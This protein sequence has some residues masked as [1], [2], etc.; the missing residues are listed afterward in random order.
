LSTLGALA[1]LALAHDARA[2]GN[3]WHLPTNPE[4]G[5]AS[6]RGPVL[7]P[8][9]SAALSIYSGNQFQG[10]GNPNNQ[11]EV[12]SMVHYRARGASS[13]SEAPLLFHSQSGNNKYFLATIAA[14]TFAAGTV[15][16]Y[17]LR[18]AYSD[19][20]TTFVHGSDHQTAATA[21]E[22][23]AQANPFRVQIAW[24]LAPS[25]S[26]TALSFG[27]F[28]A[29]VF[30]TSGH[31]ALFGPDRQGSPGTLHV[32]LAPAR[33][34]VADEWLYL[35][36]IT[37]T[38][39]ITGGLDVTHEVAGDSVV[40]R[41]TSP[42]DGVLRYEIVDWG[43]LTATKSAVM[44]SAAA[45]EH[46]YGFGEKFNSVDQAGNTVRMLTADPPGDKGDLSYKVA[47]WFVSTA[48]Y[49]FHLDASAESRFA[50]RSSAGD[51]FLVELDHPALAYHLVGGPSMSAALGRYT[52]V[53]GRAPL[54]PP[55]AF[56]PWMSS[57]HWR[58]GGEVRYVVT[59]M[60]EHD[61][62]G[63]VF[64]FDSPWETAYNDFTWNEAQFAQGGEY[65][66]RQWAGFGS[67]AEMLAFLKAQGFK[68]VLWMTPF[69]NVSSNDEGVVGQN[70]GQ[71]A[72]YAEA[73]ANGYFVRSSPGGPPLVVTWWKG[74]GSPIDF[75][76]AG[77][78][79]WLED[80]LEA[81]V[82]DGGGAIGGFKTDDGEG[83]FIPL[84]AAYSDGRTGVEMKNAYSLGYH[85]TV[86]N[87]LGDDGVLFARSGFSGSQSFPACWAGD[88]EPN[89]G[90]ENGLR[91]VIVA[92]GSA[93]MSGFAIWGH[94]IG[95]Y[96]ET[97]PSSTPE[98]LFMRWTQF[99]ALSPIMQMHRQVASN[100]H[101]PWS[102]GREAL[103]NY[104]RYAE[105][106]TRLFP[107]LY[108]YAAVARDSGLPILRPLVLRYDT[109]PETYG[110]K[111][112]YL[113][114][115]EL[116]VAPVVDNEAVEREVYLP[117]GAWY[118]YF[119]DTRYQGGRTITWQN[120]D[121]SRMP[122]FVREGAL[123]PHLST[124]PDSLVDAGY[125]DARIAVWDGDLTWRIYP[126]S[127]SSEFVMH[128][129]TRAAS[130]L[131]GDTLVVTLESEARGMLLDVLWDE[132]PAV[133]RDDEPLERVGGA[134][135]LDAATEG[136]TF[137]S[138]HV[139]V[140]LD[141]GGGTTVVRFGAPGSGG[142]G[143]AGGG[144][145]SGVGGEAPAAPGAEDGCGCRVPGGMQRTSP[146][147]LLLPW[148]FAWS[149]RRR[150]TRSSG[151]A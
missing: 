82:A 18:I 111:H 121:Q 108:S 43:G 23:T 147:V 148:L 104:R 112:Q 31:V 128:D 124:I 117:V 29:R 94:D 115:D 63:S 16:E 9:P 5:I 102:Y 140:K 110:L 33:I 35:G 98:N 60:R 15:V 130:A 36:A 6:M 54:P 66:G 143:G 42:E 58:T 14:D 7:D 87:V 134:E 51:R 122:L 28:E 38:T 151:D 22:A 73:A 132:P 86:W 40:A 68:V 107:Y 127:A 129:G 13:W 136:W 41:I 19:E 24:P 88:N 59:R 79:G 142:A 65:E 21:V 83:D 126:A 99:G 150:R 133:T 69:V 47:P 125:A 113:L 2:V 62:P 56:G 12:G 109:D 118:D 120:A 4:P 48:G 123:V 138:G 146:L 46:F 32:A 81:L 67:A 141:H 90:D 95:G 100:N 55:W 96:Q 97:N 57:D 149:W 27:E 17:Y 52:A 114:G 75:T 78:R 105:L 20:E 3:T 91:S 103:D 39:P 61:I 93:A 139:H 25:G 145:T 70:T 8:Q 26:Y 53:T 30:E 72:N 49:G 89:F 74:Q 106:H 92:G 84:G 1:L 64:V 10:A 50:M 144:L 11:L 37:D 71:A 119:D 137:V 76:H 131:D 77:A 44:G 34:E 101:Y 116:L 135:D 85:D 80:Q 45:A